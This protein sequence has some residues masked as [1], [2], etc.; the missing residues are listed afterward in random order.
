MVH[1]LTSTLGYEVTTEE[2]HHTPDCAASCHECSNTYVSASCAAIHEHMCQRPVHTFHAASCT[3]IHEPVCMYVHHQ[4]TETFGFH[5]TICVCTNTL[6]Y[7]YTIMHVKVKSH[8][9]FMIVSWISLACT[10]KEMKI[11][12]HHVQIEQKIKKQQ[13]HACYLGALHTHERIQNCIKRDFGSS[14]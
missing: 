12:S 10:C 11:R 6:M 14:M 1:I 2:L 13:Q 8:L 7:T 4:H 3:W 9:N 5:V